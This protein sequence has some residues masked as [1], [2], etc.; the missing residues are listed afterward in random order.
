M[1]HESINTS[2]AQ[3]QVRISSS[4]GWGNNGS[5]ALRNYYPAG[6][7][8]NSVHVHRLDRIAHLSG[9]DEVKIV[10]RP[11]SAAGTYGTLNSLPHVSYFTIQKLEFG[12]SHEDAIMAELSIPGLDLQTDTNAFTFNCPYNLTLQKVTCFLDTAGTSNTVVNLSGTAGSVVDITLG[13]GV[14]SR[15][16][17]NLSNASL[18]ENDRLRFSITTA[19]SGNPQGLRANTTF[20]ENI[21]AIVSQKQRLQLGL[22]GRYFNTYFSR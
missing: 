16:D 22:F 7:T 18:V 13:S 3:Y 1:Y 21:M 2:A 12:A 9:S 8:E 19:G 15:S 5:I 10:I 11:I 17:T 20:Q 6:A 14:T 4:A